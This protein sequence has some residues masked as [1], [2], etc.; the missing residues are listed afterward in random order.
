MNQRFFKSV[1]SAASL[2]IALS[3]VTGATHA[4]AQ[5]APAPATSAKP[6]FNGTWKVNLTKSQF[7]P[8][9]QPSAET[10]TLTLSGDDLTIAFDS[11]DENGKQHFTHAMK[12]GGP[13]V[14]FSTPSSSGPLLILSSKAEWKDSSIVVTD[15]ITYMGGQGWIVSTYTLS[16]DGKT[17]TKAF[18]ASIEQGTFDMLAVYDKA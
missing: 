15:K 5:A 2:A 3:A 6:D 7:S 9:P 14:T 13:E 12:M 17:L 1:L 10:T 16:P 11:T 8:A 4:T 18:S